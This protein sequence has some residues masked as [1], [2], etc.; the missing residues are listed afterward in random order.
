MANSHAV[1]VGVACP[2][3]GER[4]A[5]LEWLTLAGYEP[6]PML[7][8][9]GLAH[10]LSSRPVQ[11][12]ICDVK[13]IPK[14]D[15]PRLVK[16]LGPNRALILVGNH[17]EALEDVPRDATW[18]DRPVTRDT[19]LLSVALGLAEGR[20]SRR[21]PRK[22]VPALLSSIDGI[23][24]KVM[25]IS[26]EGVRLEITGASPASLPPFF[27]LKVPGFGVNAKVKRVWVAAP[28]QGSVWCGGVIERPN[29]KQVASWQKFIVN[30]PDMGQRIIETSAGI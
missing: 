29:A 1:K 20:P 19:F 18:M 17:D 24:S 4:A 25:D 7:N 8:I 12:L 15:L 21:S 10:E 6:V 13:L 26:I 16:A 28:D 2:I 11:A 23:S 30:S 14:K 5:F 3:P 22:L 27:T 9:E